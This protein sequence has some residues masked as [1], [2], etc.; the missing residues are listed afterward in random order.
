[1]LTFALSYELSFQAS[2][3]SRYNM[4]LKTLC[5]LSI[6]NFWNDGELRSSEVVAVPYVSHKSTSESAFCFIYVFVYFVSILRCEALWA[7]CL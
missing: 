7:A 5:L 4:L 3:I 1:M 6:C 2:P